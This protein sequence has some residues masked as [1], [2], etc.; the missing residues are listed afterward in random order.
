MLLDYIVI[1]GRR[2]QVVNRA[3]DQ[4]LDEGEHPKA[5]GIERFLSYEPRFR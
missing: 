4:D 1:G 5:F 2:E 3:L